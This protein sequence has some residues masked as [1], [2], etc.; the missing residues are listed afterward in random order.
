[1]L[2]S[3]DCSGA[4]GSMCNWALCLGVSKAV[5]S[6]KYLSMFPCLVSVFV[7]EWNLRVLELVWWPDM[8]WL[9]GTHES[10]RMWYVCPLFLTVLCVRYPLGRV[11]GG[12]V[13]PGLT[14]T[15]GTIWWYGEC[16]IT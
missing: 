15:A 16:F 5:W 9:D 1:L 10:F 13:Y 11:I 8:V 6:I 4:C 7:K 14:L 3:V 2:L 12:T